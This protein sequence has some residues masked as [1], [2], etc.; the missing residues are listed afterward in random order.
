MGILFLLS[1]VAV[2]VTIPWVGSLLLIKRPGL[3]ATFRFLTPLLLAAMLV[4]VPWL[5]RN[6]SIWGKL[7]TRTNFGMTLH[8]SNND[9][10]EPSLA[11]E[12]R[13][14]CYAATHPE[15]NAQEAALLKTL[16]EPAYDRLKIT[17][18]AS[19]IR[20][21]PGRFSRLTLARIVEFWFPQPETPSYSGYA[22]WGITILSIPG[23]FR[24]FRTRE[25]VAVFMA[26]VLLIYPPI[27]YIVVSDVRY[28]VPILWLSTLLAGYYLASLPLCR[29]WDWLRNATGSQPH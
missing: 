12:M 23:L 6:Y 7:V 19:W 20:S 2:L 9:C 27:Y 1:Q 8:A 5:A 10:A 4:N 17:E 16:G 3:R 11:M 13:N 14:G 26:A 29:G 28:R 25:P 15:G 18:G 21:H 24:L 22:I